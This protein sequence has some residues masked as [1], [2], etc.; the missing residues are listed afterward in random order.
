[1]RERTTIRGNAPQKGLQIVYTATSSI[2]P[3]N[4]DVAEGTLSEVPRTAA[5]RANKKERAGGREG[6]RHHERGPKILRE[7][8]AGARR[9]VA[10]GPTMR[11]PESGHGGKREGERATGIANEVRRDYEKRRWGRGGRRRRRQRRGSQRE[12]MA[13]SADE[14]GSV[15]TSNDGNRRERASHAVMAARSG[16]RTQIGGS[17]RNVSEGARNVDRT[18]DASDDIPKGPHKER[19]H[20]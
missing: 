16:H 13:G 10:P 3:V 20:S 9:S 15:L 7:T 19:A 17:E 18:S 12:V 14:Q 5:K 6:E 11:K 2:G 1:M 4:N 8:A